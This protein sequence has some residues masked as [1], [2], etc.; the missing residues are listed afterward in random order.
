M[1]LTREIVKTAIQPRSYGPPDPDAVYVDAQRNA[2]DL[3]ALRALVM[4]CKRYI[5]ETLPTVCSE[6]RLVEGRALLALM[7]DAPD[8]E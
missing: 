8:A 3:S 6:R 5:G 7:E 2:N 1:E 4:R